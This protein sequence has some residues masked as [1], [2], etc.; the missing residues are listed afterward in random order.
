MPENAQRPVTSNRIAH[1]RLVSVLAAQEAA[2]SP[3]RLDIGNGGNRINL[4]SVAKIMHV[5][6]AIATYPGEN[7]TRTF[8]TH[9]FSNAADVGRFAAACDRLCL[10]RALV[11]PDMAVHGALSGFADLLPKADIRFLVGISLQNNR[12]QRVGSLAVMNSS[13]A[14]ASRGI[15]FKTLTALGRAFA[16]TGRLHAELIAA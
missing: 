10:D 1:Y 13:K 5:P 16:E 9:G 4:S 3:E 8:A 7:G 2:S 11:I 14:V 15:S 6:L 12:G